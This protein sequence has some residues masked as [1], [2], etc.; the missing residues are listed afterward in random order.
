[1]TFLFSD[2]YR[3]LKIILP[4]VV[5][6]LLVFWGSR[7]LVEKEVTIPEIMEGDYSSYLGRQFYFGGRI[8]SQQGSEV[9]ILDRGMEVILSVER[10]PGIKDL[11][12]GKTIAGY[13]VL[14]PP[15]IIE[16][17]D[18]HYFRFR[19]VKIG[20]SLLISLLMFVWFWKKFRWS[21]PEMV[22]IERDAE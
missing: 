22:F 16:V 1:M 19:K 14:R 13:G 10:T 15:G 2:Q 8:L 7:Q 9:V 20:L 12:L 6:V 18:F 4:F 5:V 17:E 3:F 11:P 21:F